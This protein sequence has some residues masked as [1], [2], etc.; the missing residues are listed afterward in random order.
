MAEHDDSHHLFHLGSIH[1]GI[2]CQH[3]NL[4]RVIESECKWMCFYAQTIEIV[5]FYHE[6]GMSRF[7][8]SS[9][10][11]DDAKTR[12]E[13]TSSTRK[14]EGIFRNLLLNSIQSTRSP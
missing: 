2:A 4:S 11:Q 12:L 8:R 7:N 14:K 10:S 5:N 9:P 6:I 3:V 1:A 13:G